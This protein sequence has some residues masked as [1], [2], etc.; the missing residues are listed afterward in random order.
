MSEL[1]AHTFSYFSI[2][3]FISHHIILGAEVFWLPFSLRGYQCSHQEKPP[4]WPWTRDTSHPLSYGG[5]QSIMRG[6][7]KL[8]NP[9]AQMQPS[10]QAGGALHR[11]SFE[12][13]QMDS[14]PTPIAWAS[15]LQ[16][17]APA[18]PTVPGLQT[19]S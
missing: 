11:A 3:W 5:L 2:S 10:C 4:V 16:M 14:S 7:P 6:T 1:P 8:P 18:L 17:D 19:R 9:G 15:G 12:D 13:D